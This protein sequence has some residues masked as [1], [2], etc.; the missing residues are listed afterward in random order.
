MKAWQYVGHFLT[1]YRV[2]KHLLS[3]S[4]TDIKENLIKLRSTQINEHLIG[5]RNI[6]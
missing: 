2:N 1:D 5:L 3:L 6:Q 4:R